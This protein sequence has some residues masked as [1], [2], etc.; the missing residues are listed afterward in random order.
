MYNFSDEGVHFGRRDCSTSAARGV[1]L[2]R[3]IHLIPFMPMRTAIDFVHLLANVDFFAP[4]AYVFHWLHL[5]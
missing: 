3:Y 4:N 5:L 1:Q 2:E